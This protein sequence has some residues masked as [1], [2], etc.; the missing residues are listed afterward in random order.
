[1]TV[2]DE[3]RQ[4]VVSLFVVVLLGLQA[5]VGFGL[6]PGPVRPSPYLWPILDYPMYARPNYE[7]DEVVREFVVG[8]RPDST[9]V[10]IAPEGFGLGTVTDEDRTPFWL[11]M[12]GPV[13]ALYEGDEEQARRYRDAYVRRHGG[14]LIALQ[15]RA[16]PV[17]ITREGY[18]RRAERILA[19]VSFTH[20]PQRGSGP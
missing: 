7:G 4:A 1:M 18:E 10:R 16:R 15:L 8:V 12:D 2:S 5:M 3:L 9:L 19:S 17:A 11:Y 13:R 20:G 14:E 6:D